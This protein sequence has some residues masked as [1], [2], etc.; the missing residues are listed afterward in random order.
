M[1][2]RVACRRILLTCGVALL[3]LRP[4]FL[5]AAEKAPATL[6]A[7]LHDRIV[8]QYMNGTWDELTKEMMSEAKGIGALPPAQ[9][10]N[11]DYIRRTIAES[12]PAWWKQC[13]AGQ[14][15]RFHPAPWGKTLFAIYDPAAK[16]SSTQFLQRRANRHRRLE[17]RRH[18]QSG[19]RRRIAVHQRRKC[20]PGTLD[21]ARLGGKLGLDSGSGNARDGRTGASGADP[22]AGLSR[23]HMRRLLRVAA[24]AG[25]RSGT[26][27][28]DGVT[29]MT[30]K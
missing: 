7:G 13:K 1:S 10:A 29:S 11:V 17:R 5:S 14:K 6:P 15:F 22:I 28:P 4:S 26:A 3:I 2:L 27:S 18:G 21:H 9:K 19:D 8:A 20:G 30:K 25:W 16:M 12:R 23:Q 24:P